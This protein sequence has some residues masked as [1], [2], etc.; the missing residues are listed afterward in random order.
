[1]VA[2]LTSGRY[3]CAHSRLQWSARIFRHVT[4]DALIARAVGLVVRVAL[5]S[6][7]HGGHWVS[8]VRGSPGRDPGG[9]RRLEGYDVPCAS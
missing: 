9:L 5:Q 1:V 6:W 8:R 4:G 7:P 3:G 2:G